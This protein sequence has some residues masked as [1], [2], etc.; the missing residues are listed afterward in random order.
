MSSGTNAK[1]RRSATASL[2]EVRNERSGST[3]CPQDLAPPFC[4]VTGPSFQLSGAPV[5][6]RSPAHEVRLMYRPD[7]VLLPH[8]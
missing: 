8:G 6:P 1:D 7:T 4:L 5:R 2:R 3:S